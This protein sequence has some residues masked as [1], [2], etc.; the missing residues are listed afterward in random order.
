MSGSVA[1]AETKVVAAEAAPSGEWVG[2]VLGFD[3]VR[4][5]N[6]LKRCKLP[7]GADNELINDRWGNIYM[8]RVHYAED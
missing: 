6:A 3:S 8:A 5:K 4:W 7:A 2:L 1:L